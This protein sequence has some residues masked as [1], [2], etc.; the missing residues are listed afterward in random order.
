MEHHVEIGLRILRDIE[1]LSQ[2]EPLIRYHQ[3]RWDGATKGVDY[4]GYFGLA[5]EQIPLGA[6][7][8]AVVDAFDAITHDRPYRRGRPM[9]AAIAELERE[10]GKQFDPR[11]VDALLAVVR[12]EQLVI[13]SGPR[14]L[15]Q[16]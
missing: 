10:A 13:E 16:A 9:R 5:G 2:I 4:A 12:R 3:E 8:L 7:V 1:W 15:A 11:V 6:R 14:A